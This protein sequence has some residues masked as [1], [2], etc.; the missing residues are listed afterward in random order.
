MSRLS[1]AQLSDEFDVLGDGQSLGKDVGCHLVSRAVRQVNFARFHF[2][3]NEVMLYVDMF[4]PSMIGWVSRRG[5]APLIVR[6][7]NKRP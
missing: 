3:S 7:N 6:M 1:E 2:F 4:G 5:N